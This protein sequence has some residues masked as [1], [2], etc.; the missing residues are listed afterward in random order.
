MKIATWNVNSVRA[1]LRRVLAWIDEARP[2]VLL[3]QE[4]KVPAEMFPLEPF[5]ELAYNVVAA[6]ETS[7]ES[8]DCALSRQPLSCSASTRTRGS[9]V[10][11]P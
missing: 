11:A 1:R 3:L 9:W 4:T 10:I 2:D 7:A 6:G 5:D 8:A